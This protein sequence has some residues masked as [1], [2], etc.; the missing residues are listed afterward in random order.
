MRDPSICGGLYLRL[1]P[2]PQGFT[3]QQT[4]KSKR[5]TQSGGLI[6]LRS[7]REGIMAYF[8]QEQFT[9]DNR[10]FSRMRNLTFGQC[11]TIVGGVFAW[12]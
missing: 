12:L 8:D 6:W 4:A 11:M 2:R 7:E 3:H 9:S 5:G 10:R 1:P